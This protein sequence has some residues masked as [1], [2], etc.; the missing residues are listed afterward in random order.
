MT[1]NSD[2]IAAVAANGGLSQSEND[3]HLKTAEFTWESVDGATPVLNAVKLPAGSKVML[4][5][6]KTAAALGTS[7]TFSA[8]GVTVGAAITTTGAVNALTGAG[9][10]V[11][12]GS[13]GLVILTI[14]GTVASTPAVTGV[15]Y[16][17]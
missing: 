3:A 2:E 11:V 1:Y 9:V 12:V 13:D 5:G 6:L 8:G 14:A 10:G 7:A 16:Y 17:V 15:V 4:A